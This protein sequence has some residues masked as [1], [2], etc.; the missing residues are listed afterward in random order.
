MLSTR[1]GGREMVPNVFILFTD[2]NS[3]VDFEK[4]AS[5]LKETGTTVIVVGIGKYPKDSQMETIA[6]PGYV[7]RVTSFKMLGDVA[8]KLASLACK[9]LFSVYIVHCPLFIVH[10]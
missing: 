2:G 1:N 6:S 8:G 5:T 3:H 4:A 9:G 7:L 10:K